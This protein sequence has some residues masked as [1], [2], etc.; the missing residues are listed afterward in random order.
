MPENTLREEV[1]RLHANICS[2]LADPN[3]ILIIY[4]LSDGP[5]N[6]TDIAAALELAQPTVSRHLKILRERGIVTPERDGQNI[7]YSLSDIRIIQALD[8]LRSALA[9]MLKDTAVLAESVNNSI[10]G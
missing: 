5:R 7:N 1:V 4:S 9:D 10:S 8:L 2:G 3:R 6:V